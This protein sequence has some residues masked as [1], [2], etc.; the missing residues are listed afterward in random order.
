MEKKSVDKKQL[1]KTIALG[2]L[3]F[4]LTVLLVIPGTALLKPMLT[5]AAATAI[6]WIAQSFLVICFAANLLYSIRLDRRAEDRESVLAELNTLRAN[7]EESGRKLGQQ[8]LRLARRTDVYAVALLLAATV[9]GLFGFVAPGGSIIP[10]FAFFT[11]FSRYWPD[12]GDTK[13]LEEGLTPEE[14]VPLQYALARQAQAVLGDTRPIGILHD[15]QCTASIISTPGKIYLCLGSWLLDCMTR[16]EVY[17]VLLHEF[18]H[19]QDSRQEKL[20]RRIQRCGNQGDVFFGAANRLEGKTWSLH[21]IFASQE[22]EER[23]DRAIAEFGNPQAAASAFAKLACHVYYEGFF[24]NSGVIIEKF[25][26]ETMP[27]HALQQL[28]EDFRT[29]VAGNQG[30]ARSLIAGELQP[31]ISS[32]PIARERIA[33]L[34][35]TDYSL[36]LPA[37]EDAW[38]QEVQALVERQEQELYEQ[39]RES[40]PQE[41]QTWYLEP[42]ERLAA[43]EAG[44]RP[45]TYEATREVLETLYDRRRYEEIVALG[46]A[47][48]ESGA[49]EH[50]RCHALFVEGLARLRLLDD[51]GLDL[52]YQA[53]EVNRNYEDAAGEA[54]SRYCCTL[55]KEAEMNRFRSYADDQLARNVQIL[56]TFP[57]SPRDDL[58]PTDRQDAIFQE[59][60]EV[61]CRAAGAQLNRV[62]LVKK[63]TS[64]KTH[65]YIYILDLDPQMS[66]EAQEA[67]Y[68]TIFMH[69]DKQEEQYSL[70][71]YGPD[72]GK[73][74]IEK[75][76]EYLIYTK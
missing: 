55:G 16:E 35:V 49:S 7:R 58:L 51:S 14:E 2:A 70:A 56:P 12:A 4:V 47:F 62:F 42:M 13:V 34:G 41:R 68:D 44:G 45:M 50:E 24:L 32:H 26:E 25:Q 30:W 53:M 5:D 64:P 43:W 46:R 67:V 54:I 17:Q 28:F 29:A 20:N 10:I 18:A 76:A 72:T 37:H 15:A 73:D 40:Y 48:R 21:Q 63:I 59:N 66:E 71:Y 65:D 39:N 33:A 52:L 8:L 61:I 60:L 74:W 23:A 22:A 31:R 38:G 75:R 57:L 3:A 9:S 69:L 1:G 27:R 11:L 36:E 19:L 6:Y